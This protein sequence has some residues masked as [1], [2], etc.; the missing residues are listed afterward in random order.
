[1]SAIKQSK[2]DRVFNAVNIILMI[3]IMLIM[4]YPLYFTVIASVS[5]PYAVANGQVSLLPVRFTL[6]PY[7]NV[8]KES[9]I[10]IG[11][12]NTLVYT[13][14][15][16]AWNLILTIPAAYVLSKKKLHGRTFI[17]IYFLI[18]MYFGGGLIPTYLQIKNMGL[19]NK[20][21]TLII[22][23]GL[24]PGS[25]IDRKNGTLYEAAAPDPLFRVLLRSLKTGE[26]HMLTSESDWD[27][28]FEERTLSGWAF[29]FEKDGVE[30][31]VSA[32]AAPEQSR[33]FFA[34]G[35]GQDIPVT[36]CTEI[37]DM[38]PYPSIGVCMAYLA[39]Y[40]AQKRRG[41]YC[42]F[43]DPLACYKML[44]ADCHDGVCRAEAFIPARGIDEAANGFHMD[45]QDVW[46]LFDD[47]WYDASLIYRGWVHAC[48][49]WFTGIEAAQRNDVPEW[50]L[51]MPLWFNCN[52]EQSAQWME[53]LF[54]AQADFAKMPV[55]VHMYNW[56]E[57]PFDTNYPHYN[58]A[59]AD[60][61]RKLPSCR[62]AA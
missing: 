17:S 56:H 25:I 43:Q 38:S 11:Y 23:G 37:H 62:R 45:G 32:V 22:L 8:F 34:L 46:Q 48:A 31:Q 26:E 13:V 55:G 40:D 10:W 52:I 39:L 57:I 33:I 30:V 35:P 51:K 29:R 16:T 1:M 20:P 3:I 4:L 24:S 58:P 18:P 27:G 2:G 21:Y 19:L 6:E 15:G 5:D 12:R 47:D 36:A 44:L 59:K 28:V 61:V 14:L 42:G 49:N 53:K 60:F 54:E 9:R 41:L 50:L 7:Q